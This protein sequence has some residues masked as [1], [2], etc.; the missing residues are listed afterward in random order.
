[1]KA[2][3]F[4]KSLFFVGFFICIGNYF[5]NA[6][7]ITETKIKNN[8]FL[9]KNPN[10]NNKGAYYYLQAA[11]R[12]NAQQY[13]AVGMSATLVL[14]GKTHAYS[15]Y[16]RRS[17]DSRK[18]LKEDD[19]FL[20]G[21][22][23]KTVTSYLT[24]V[25]IHK[26][27]S[28]ISWDTRV[29]DVYPDLFWS[30]GSRIGYSSLSDFSRHKPYLSKKCFTH[31]SC[32]LNGFTDFGCSEPACTNSPL[33]SCT[34]DKSNTRSYLMCGRKELL[35]KGLKRA[36]R[37]VGT[38]FE[39]NNFHPV[40]MSGFL[41]EIFDETY[42][43]LL[44]DHFIN[45][46]RLNE[47]NGFRCRLS[48]S[49][50]TRMVDE[51]LGPLGHINGVVDKS[52]GTD[53]TRYHLGH[54]SGG[55]AMSPRSMGRYLEAM[56]DANSPY[57]LLP[58]SAY[59]VLFEGLEDNNI[60]TNSGWGH[61]RYRSFPHSYSHNGRLYGMYTKMRFFKPENWGWAVTTT[62][63]DSNDTHEEATKTMELQLRT[64]Y[65]NRNILHHFEKDKYI[66][67]VSGQLRPLFDKDFRTTVSPFFNWIN[68]AVIPNNHSIRSVVLAYPSV[69]NG[70]NLSKIKVTYKSGS[71]Y[72][73][74]AEYDVDPVK[75]EFNK[76]ISF[77]TSKNTKDIKLELIKKRNNREKTVVSEVILV[78]AMGITIGG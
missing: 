58:E 48:S 64:M 42:E 28:R 15:V 3:L 30:T 22:I 33:D 9:A 36:G 49:F 11:L 69:R 10:E 72:R 32:E 18:R 78:P 61:S 43:K 74:L 34:L 2:F 27:P 44:K 76:T 37:S 60:R 52:Y 56:I 75:D 63:V 4:L 55:L 68:L 8:T 45:P 14:D 40:I 46:M 57:S 12:R 47:G 20:I 77:R 71:S 35:H 62:S 26:Y 6:Q 51:V 25:L 19:M 24:G 23:T 7:A 16:G 31:A 39:Y 1:M 54:A 59:N 17:I 70:N 53:K 73:L 41:Q 66:Q 29:I 67:N 38:R 21:S 50:L 5:T 65:S 13:G